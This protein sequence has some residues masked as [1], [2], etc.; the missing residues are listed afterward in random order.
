VDNDTHIV[1]YDSSM[2]NSADTI[3]MFHSHAAEK[4]HKRLSRRR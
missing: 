4:K 3:F 1:L 2:T